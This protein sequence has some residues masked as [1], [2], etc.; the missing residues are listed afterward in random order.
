MRVGFRNS[1]GVALI[2][3]MIWLA[4]ESGMRML[5]ADGVSKAVVGV[6]QKAPRLA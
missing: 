3:Q 6:V 1:V 2:D 4:V 5:L